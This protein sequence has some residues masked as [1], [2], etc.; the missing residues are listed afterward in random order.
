MRINLNIFYG[1]IAI[2]LW[3][4]TVALVRS[5]TGK[6][7]A[8]QTGFLTFT[9]SGIAC[10]LL[11]LFYID[12]KSVLSH[13]V[14]YFAVC[15]LLFVLY[16]V[17]LF[18]AIERAKN[19][20]QAMELGLVNY[21]W[22]TLTVILSLIIV[23][24]NVTVLIVPGIL[25][26]IIGIFI[27]ITQ[28]GSISLSVFIRNIRSNFAAYLSAFI[29]AVV[30][31]IYSNLTNL[32][33][34][35]NSESAVFVFIPF[36]ALVFA[37]ITFTD[38]TTKTAVNS[39]NK[40]TITE[41]IVLSVFTLLAYILWDISMRKTNVTAVAVLSYFTPFFSTLTVSIYL[42]EKITKKLWLGC[43]LLIL[44]SLL[45]WLSIS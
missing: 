40:K 4:T 32:W 34:N 12:I 1:I 6:I 30:W 27:V 35:P 13:S 38:K 17:S 5:I 37:A 45:S 24:Q 25:I 31:A 2:L 43:F 7:T 10:L 20:Q 22:P 42:K 16:M 26:S 28:H 8:I 39:L 15:G 18:I 3:S 44:G 19:T 14:L 33:G 21:L 36:A 41:I 11:M 9:F 23:E 29:A